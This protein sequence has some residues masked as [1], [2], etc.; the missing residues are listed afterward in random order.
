[1]AGVYP[2]CGRSSSP[3]RTRRPRSEETGGEHLRRDDAG[4]DQPRQQPVRLPPSG[5]PNRGGV[6][7]GI[8]EDDDRGPIVG[9]RRYTSRSSALE[10]VIVGGVHLLQQLVRPLLFRHRHRVAGDHRHIEGIEPEMGGEPAIAF[11]LAVLFRA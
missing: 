1:M 7:L 9:T 4:I 5:L 2:A 6:L 8:A 3:G 10:D 11:A